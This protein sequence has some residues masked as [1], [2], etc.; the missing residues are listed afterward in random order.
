MHH[1]QFPVDDSQSD[2]VSYASLYMHERLYARG[3]ISGFLVCC[4]FLCT[5]MHTPFR[6]DIYAVWLR[7]LHRAPSGSR[8]SVLSLGFL[9]HLFECLCD[10]YNVGVL[11][12]SLL[13]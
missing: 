3:C 10:Y 7:T 6:L 13:L 11:C 2:G 4:S 1:G 5:A 12:S 8:V 9:R